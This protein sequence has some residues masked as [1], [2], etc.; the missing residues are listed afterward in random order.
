MRCDKE[1]ISGNSDD[2]KSSL[3]ALN[4]LW[5]TLASKM[6]ESNQGDNSEPKTSS[7]KEKNKKETKDSEIEDADF[8]VVD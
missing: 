8:E 4:T 1:S 2:I 6:V 3:E 5:S 7:K